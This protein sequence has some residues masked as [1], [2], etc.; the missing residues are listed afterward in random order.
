MRSFGAFVLLSIVLCVSVT[1]ASFTW[2]VLVVSD[3]TGYSASFVDSAST[4]FTGDASDG[5]VAND[6]NE[7]E[8]KRENNKP[9][10][11]K[12]QMQPGKENTE[13]Q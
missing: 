10:K 7:V 8:G 1:E 9:T 13:S 2:E 5:A 6:G 11:E 4:N 3:N 12:K